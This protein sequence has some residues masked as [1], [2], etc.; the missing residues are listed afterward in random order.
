MKVN[1]AIPDLSKSSSLALTIFSYWAE[2]P[3]VKLDVET[4]R[5]LNASIT[6]YIHDDSTRQAILFGQWI[7][8]RG[9]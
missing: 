9:F 7:T 4:I 5:D 1:S 3:G 2:Q 6:G 8:R